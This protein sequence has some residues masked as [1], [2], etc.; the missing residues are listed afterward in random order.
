MPTAHINVRNALPAY[1]I[2]ASDEHERARVER[3]LA[4]CALCEA[5]LAH[6]RDV[7]TS[8]LAPDCDP[9]KGVWRRVSQAIQSGQA[10]DGGASRVTTA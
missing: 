8:A 6:L 3:H 10:E 1:A 7:A 4:V 2:G 9:P 5:E